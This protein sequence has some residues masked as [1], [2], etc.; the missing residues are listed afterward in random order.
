MGKGSGC[1]TR[2][3]PPGPRGWRRA[4]AAAGPAPISDGW[5]PETRM[6]GTTTRREVTNPD[7]ADAS[8]D[9]ERAGHDLMDL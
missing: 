7:D 6:C 3:A 5:L 8:G 4:R 1:R 9:E 2:V